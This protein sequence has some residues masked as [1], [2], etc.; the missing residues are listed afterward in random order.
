MDKLDEMLLTLLTG[1]T[2]G[3][4]FL[5]AELPEVIQQ[6]LHWYFA[7][8]VIYSFVGFFLAYVTYR[9]VKFAIHFYK[10]DDSYDAAEKTAFIILISVIIGVLSLCFINLDW[11][12]I[13]IAPKVW[14]IEYASELVKPTN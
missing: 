1:I 2:E 4:Q 9:I 3:G 7:K 11:L 8:S 13:L 10:T 14:L 5:V 12:Q 6:L